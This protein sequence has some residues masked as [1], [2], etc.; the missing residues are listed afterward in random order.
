MHHLQNVRQLSYFCPAAREGL[1]YA[2]QEK[3]LGLF[4]RSLSSE[5][6]LDPM[7]LKVMTAC[8]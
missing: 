5:F 7:S 1:A 3:W 8:M 6:D 4:G 2:A